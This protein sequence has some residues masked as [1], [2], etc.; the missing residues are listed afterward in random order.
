LCFSFYVIFVTLSYPTSDVDVCI[1]GRH[2]PQCP[3]Q[4]TLSTGAVT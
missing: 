1:S 2:C 3:G 4:V